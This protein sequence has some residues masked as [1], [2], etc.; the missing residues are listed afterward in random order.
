MGCFRGGTGQGGMAPWNAEGAAGNVE[1]RGWTEDR[2]TEKISIL[3]GCW[4]DERML[5][6]G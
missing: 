3:G 2:V 6:R 1:A 5:G 4:E